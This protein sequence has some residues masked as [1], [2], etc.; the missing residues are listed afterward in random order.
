MSKQLCNEITK[1]QLFHVRLFLHLPQRNKGN[2]TYIIMHSFN[3]EKVSMSNPISSS[4]SGNLEETRLVYVRN[5]MVNKQA[6]VGC[7]YLC[8]N[9]I[10]SLL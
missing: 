10:V 7:V 3:T 2:C 6:N 4:V 9:I 5:F 1:I 8:L